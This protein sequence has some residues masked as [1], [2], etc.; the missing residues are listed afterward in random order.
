MKHILTAIWWGCLL[1]IATLAPLTAQSV[2]YPEKPSGAGTQSSP[3]E[4]TTPAHLAW[5]AEMVNGGESLSGVWL[6]QKC[7]IDLS[8]TKELN[9]GEGWTPIG[10]YVFLGGR[11]IKVGFEGY[12]DGEGHTISNLYMNRPQHDYQALF[13]YVH[14]G[15]VANLTIHKGTVTGSENVAAA[16]AYTF[17]ETISNC[18]VTESVVDCKAFYAGGLIGFQ[19]DG[20]TEHSSAQ[21]TI[22]GRDY[23][24]G[25]VGWSE[26]GRIRGCR[27]SGSLLSVVFNGVQPRH[28]GGLV[29]Y[30]NKSQIDRSLCSSDLIEGGDWTG[31]LVGSAEQSKI[32]ESVNLAKRITGRSYVGGIAG[33][34]NESELSDCYSISSLQGEQYVGGVSGFAT[35]SSTLIERLYSI[36]EVSAIEGSSAFAIGSVLGA[37]GTGTVRDV[38]YDQT[39]QPDL[40]AIGGANQE[41]C[42]VTGKNPDE[43]K[44][45][46]S[47]AG[48]DFS[49]IWTIVPAQHDGLPLLRWQMDPAW[50]AVDNPSELLAASPIQLIT[51]GD[52][53][54]LSVPAPLTLEVVYG[55]DGTALTMISRNVNSCRVALP[56]QARILI[57]VYSDGAQYHTAKCLL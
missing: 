32:R 45:Q 54:Y 16:F 35:Y 11:E 20:V 18:H 1:I 22:Y 4:V 40:P 10:G 46:E 41:G 38:L 52:A 23:I 53:C 33:R 9:D 39:K 37:Y 29:G 21:V 2:L 7:D 24:G 27:T 3:L 19:S 48:W 42:K 6:A 47:Y 15:R 56:A 31:G 5:I 8:I 51:E 36:C 12:Y 30:C 57:I 17:E 49:E 28:C 13:G 44:Q 55:I 14:K 43:M 25:L 26:L 34:T 50:N